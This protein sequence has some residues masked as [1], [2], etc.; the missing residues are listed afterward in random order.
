MSRIVQILE[1]LENQL[2]EKNIIKFSVTVK[3]MK[4]AVPSMPQPIKKI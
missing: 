3:S 4:S 1:K 2:D